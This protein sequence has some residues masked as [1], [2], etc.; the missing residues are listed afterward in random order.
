MSFHTILV[1]RDTAEFAIP[2]AARLAQSSHAALRVMNA[3]H[4]LADLVVVAR[5]GQEK[6]EGFWLDESTEDLLYHQETPLLLLGP[7]DEASSAAPCRLRSILVALDLST[8]SE[9]VLD[10][11]TALANLSDGHITLAH[12]LEPVSDVT[13]LARHRELAQRQLDRVADRLRFRGLSVSTRLLIET[14]PALGLLN[15]L[16]QQCYD[17]IALTTH[18][19]GGLQRLFLGS[20]AESLIRRAPKPVLVVRP[21]DAAATHGP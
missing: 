1:P 12:V 9:A 14:S 10:P 5:H 13:A 6:L 20:V 11:V 16:E 17:V 15:E 7:E 2:V 4:A 18:G 3:P 8:A 19:Q 21:H